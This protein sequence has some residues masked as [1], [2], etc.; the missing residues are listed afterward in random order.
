[1][2]YYSVLMLLL[3]ASNMFGQTILNGKIT[4]SETGEKMIGANIVIKQDGAY[5]AGVSAD[6]DG[7]EHQ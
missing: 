5:K 1:M 2:K 6:F 7:K 3:V 4:D